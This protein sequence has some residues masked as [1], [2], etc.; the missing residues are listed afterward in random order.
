[1]NVSNCY[2]GD[3][4]SGIEVAHTLEFCGWCGDNLI[5]SHDNETE[6]L[7]ISGSGYMDDYTLN[8][9]ASWNPLSD[10]IKSVV[11][12]DGVASIGSFAFMGYNVTSVTFSNSVKSIGTS[13]F[14]SC[15]KL[16]SVHIPD[17]VTELGSSAFKN[18]KNLTSAIIGDSLVFIGVS[19]FEGC[20]NLQSLKF[21]KSVSCINSSAF[22][23]CF[24]L[25]SLEIPNTVR[26]IDHRAFRECT[27]LK[28]ITFPDSLEY[29]GAY[30]FS[31]CSSIQNIIIPDSVK[32][33]GMDAF[34]Q[35][36]SLISVKLSASLSEL[37]YG[38]FSTCKNL[39][40]IVIPASVT[41]IDEMVFYRCS[42]LKT[43]VIPASVKVIERVAFSGCTS[44]ESLTY[45]GISS[46]EISKDET[47]S[48]CNK[49]KYVTVPE[50][51]DSSSFS[52]FEVVK[53]LPCLLC[54]P[55]AVYSFDEA[56]GL[57]SISGKGDMYDFGSSVPVPWSEYC[58]SSQI[59]SVIIGNNITS[60][61]TSS[62]AGCKGLLTAK[63]SESVA[64]IGTKAF[65]NCKNLETVWFE[66]TKPPGYSDSVYDGCNSLTCINVPETYESNS[67]CG[68][69]ICTSASSSS[70]SQ[71]VKSISRGLPLAASKMSVIFMTIFSA[72]I[73][74]IH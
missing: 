21:G 72:I 33:I 5:W 38:C 66:G 47:F 23:Q 74:H 41:V 27:N 11:I 19:S 28:N 71:E 17:S 63:I 8:T 53:S 2:Q 65:Y 42:G 6:T 32:T 62:F 36:Y 67:F 37:S 1:V 64:A 15:R 40:D 34:S 22:R 50:C 3:L 54:G 39:T 45:L 52:Q 44:L 25:E 18:C 4:F 58:S 7:N 57:L 30:A 49:L 26:I 46:P 29:I 60:I 13:A 56:S 68:K 10:S 73:L 48:K 61:G 70:S 12:N 43:V 51:Y 69:P 14:E 35:C 16:Q 20:N 59:K 55:N 24:G 31:E 9:F